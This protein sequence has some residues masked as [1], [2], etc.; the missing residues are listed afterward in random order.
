MNIFQA[1]VLGI[2]QGLTEFLPVSSSAHLRVVP[3]L[4][5]WDDPGA[6]FTAVTQIGTEAAVLIYF[7]HDLIRMAR[8]WWTSLRERTFL[9]ST[10]PD[11]RLAWYV[12]L[13][14][15]PIGVLG[16]L[17]EDLIESS[18]RDLRVTATMLIVIGLGLLVAER[19]G[20]ARKQTEDMTLRDAITLGFAQALALIPGVSR[21]GATISGGLLLG[22]DRVAATRFA[23]LLAIP[24]VVL[25]GLFKL[26]DAFGGD[27]P[28]WGATL[29]ATALAFVTGYAAIAWLLRYI[30]KNSFLPFVIYRVALGLLLWVL[31]GQGVLSPV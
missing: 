28:G 9:R 1:S 17:L 19:M 16:L 14:T 29:S 30:S 20:N 10:D 31:I 26:P 3:A 27:G 23:F 24:A 22:Y 13:G 6:A 4:L 12:A 8:A 25:S 15:V 18:F 5:G 21:S 11:A 2:V 7:R